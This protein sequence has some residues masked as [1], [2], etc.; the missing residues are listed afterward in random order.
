MFYRCS[1]MY[2]LSMAVGFLPVECVVK[3]DLKH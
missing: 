1:V 3:L 2:T